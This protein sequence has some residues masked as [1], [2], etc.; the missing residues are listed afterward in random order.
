MT[1]HTVMTRSSRSKKSKTKKENTTRLHRVV[2]PLPSSFKK[3]TT[4]LFIYLQRSFQ[5]AKTAAV[6]TTPLPRIQK[7]PTIITT[8]NAIASGGVCDKQSFLQGICGILTNRNKDVIA[9]VGHERGFI[10]DNE[11]KFERETLPT[12]LPN[13][14]YS[15]FTRR[16]KRWKFVS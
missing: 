15:I 3:I 9:W 5:L 10:I 2:I 13:N 1:P 4:L 11:P 12:C 14:K 6:E 7:N 16:L 8:R